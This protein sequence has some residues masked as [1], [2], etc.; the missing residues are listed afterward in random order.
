MLRDLE[1]ATG[2]SRDAAVAR[3]AVI[4]TRSVEGLINLVRGG[5]AP[6]ARAGALAALEAIADPRADDIALACLDDPDEGVR[7]GAAALARRLLD[8]P[9]GAA[10]LDRLTALAVDASRTDRSRLAAL[11]AMRHVPGPALELLSARLRQDPSA[12]VRASVLGSGGAVVMPP[13][14]ALESAASATLPDDPDAM[15]QWLAAAGAQAPL[16]TLHRI[17]QRVREREKA[18]AD[19]A[20]RGSWM[21]VRAV[22]HQVLAERGSTV[23]LYDLRETIESG[24]PAAVE[25]LAALQVIGDRTCLEPVAA[26]YSRLMTPPGT[27][28]PQTGRAPSEW[29]RDHLEV[30]FRAIAAREKVTERHAVTR[31]VRSRWPDAARVLL[32]PPK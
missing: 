12:A 25:M 23:A 3:L 8:S 5:A 26:A 1:S 19:P 10:V 4:G 24:E 13:L 14:E 18:T 6:A 31:R 17:V 27:R 32:G 7:A 30:A 28:P 16:P 9:R 21:T 22:A 29:W 11:D 2:A 20:Q 15:R